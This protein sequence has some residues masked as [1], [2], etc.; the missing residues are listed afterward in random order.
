MGSGTGAVISCSSMG[1]GTGAVISGSSMGSG[2]G[3]VISGSSMGSGTGA[4]ISGSG[5]GKGTSSG[6]TPTNPKTSRSAS[7]RFGISPRSSVFLLLRTTPFTAGFFSLSSLPAAFTPPIS[8]DKFS[9][10]SD[11]RLSAIRLSNSSMKLSTLCPTFT[12]LS[13]FLPAVLKRIALSFTGFLTGSL[14][15]VYFC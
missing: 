10:F 1:S 2:T 7:S 6:S 15:S 9:A 5:T 14:F 12:G 11:F 13:V 8:A 3:A 4:V